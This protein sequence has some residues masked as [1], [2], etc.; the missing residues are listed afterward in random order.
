MW[1]IEGQDL[2]T[3]ATESS[4]F[5]D[6]RVDGEISLVSISQKL[7]TLI[8]GHNLHSQRRMAPK[9]PVPKVCVKNFL[10]ILFHSW[11]DEIF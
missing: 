8:C 10:L 11:L 3:E 2:A 1:F 4:L 6:G 7:E 5:S 9:P